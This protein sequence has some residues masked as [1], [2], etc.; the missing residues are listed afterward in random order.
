MGRTNFSDD[1]MYRLLVSSVKDHAIYMLDGNGNVLNWNA[2]AEHIK[3]YAADEIIGKNYSCFFSD[4]DRKRRVPWDNLE[5]AQRLGHFA[6]E[7]W[8]YR[9]DRTAFWASVVID[10]VYNPDG[11]LLG[12]AKVTRDLTE[13]QE[14]N[15]RFE[16]QA[17]HDSLTGVYNR[18]G[19]QEKLEEQLPQVAYGSRIAVHYL[20][21]DRFKAVNDNHGHEIGDEVLKSA[22]RRF[23]SVLGHNGVVGRLGGDEFVAL[24]FGSPTLDAIQAAANSLVE[25]MIEPVAVGGKLA[26]VGVS[27]GTAIA[28]FN[29]YD[30]DTILRCADLALYQAKRDGRGCARQY[31]DE[32]DT[33]A[34]ARTALELEV[35]EAV[36]RRLFFLDY[37][38]IIDAADGTVAGYEALLR[39]QASTGELISPSVFIP[40]VEE[41]GFIT[42]LGEWV[43]RTACSEAMR[44]SHN[45]Y[46][47]VNVSAAQLGDTALIQIIDQ[48][49]TDTGLAPE[50]LELEI[51]E[52]TVLD[53]VKTAEGVL[54]TLRNRGIGIALDDFG[55]GFSSLS[56][57]KKL[58]LT[59][60]KIDKSFVDQIGDDGKSTAVIDAVL[61][62]CDG[63]GL[64]TTAEGVETSNQRYILTAKGCDALQ[65]FLFGK[66]GSADHERVDNH[67]D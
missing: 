38:P 35:R 21:L 33:L 22:T 54:R 5:T 58:P 63:Y 8:R 42:A 53:N 62:L 13:Q 56:L 4:D 39:W 65:G 64:S 23:Q 36:D 24:Q 32:M 19:I 37:Q 29:G 30:T 66:P 9:K 45:I 41:L 3:G 17:R 43:L 57:V 12:F 7:G 40:I 28:P 49:L 27:V 18:R 11:L 47:S 10:P 25:A 1:I 52:S 46:I 26:R 48:I 61:A 44:W 16:H 14:A 2:G 55:T 6:E 34:R 51:T 31:S 15:R 20:D 59:R 67:L 60:I 50:R